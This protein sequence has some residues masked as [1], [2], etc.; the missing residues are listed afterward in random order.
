MRLLPRRFPRRFAAAL[1]AAVMLTSATACTGDGGAPA[2]TGDGQSPPSLLDSAPVATESELAAS[3]TAQAIKERGQLL[4]GGVVNMPLLSQRNP[5]TGQT[6]GFDALLARM[7]AKYIIGEPNT[8]RV[9][10][11]PDTRE[12]MLQIN[13]VDVVVRIYT[14]NEERAKKVS[15]AGPY[16]YSG[17]AIATLKSTKTINDVSDLAGDTVLAVNGAT[18]V[19]AIKKAVPGIEVKTYRTSPEC[20]QA[21]E[22]GEGIAYIHD[23]ALLA[24]AAQLNQKLQ[25]VGEP[26]TKEPYGIGVPHGDKAF[27]K[28]INDWLRKIEQQGL[29]TKAWKQ[30]L[31][32][33]VAGEAPEPPEPASVPGT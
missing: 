8:K 18:S 27:K 11:T 6:E 10:A 22:N 9:T 17:Q 23:L 21:L 33:V 26:F 14:I 2:T 31:G 3:P 19:D 15:F 1:G 13:T 5:A 7:L 24:G 32:T 29:W 28:F 25:I 20:V 4:V 16:L 12:T 30:T